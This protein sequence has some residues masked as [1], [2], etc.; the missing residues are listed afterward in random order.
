MINLV[1]KYKTKLKQESTSTTCFL[2][3]KKES[4][5]VIYHITQE[6]KIQMENNNSNFLLIF[7]ITRAMIFFKD[8]KA[9]IHRSF[10]IEINSLCQ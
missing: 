9:K 6:V 3:P 8:K 5:S 10:R 7:K 2:Y 4:F 1:E